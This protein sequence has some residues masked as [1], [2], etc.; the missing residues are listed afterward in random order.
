MRLRCTERLCPFRTAAQRASLSATGGQLDE[1]IDADDKDEVPDSDLFAEMMQEDDE[2]ES[3]HGVEEVLADSMAD[4]GE[5]KKDYIVDLW[6]FARPT[7][8]YVPL[9]RDF[10]MAS[11]GAIC[12]ILTSTAHPASSL[13]AREL[14]CEAY[15]MSERLK[16]HSLLHAQD[17]GMR[18]FLQK[19][20]RELSAADLL[21]GAKR[22]FRPESTFAPFGLCV[23]CSFFLIVCWRFWGVSFV[24][25]ASCFFGGWVISAARPLRTCFAT[26]RRF[27]STRLS[28]MSPAS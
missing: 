8:H 25:V 19:H 21:E 7:A 15:V 9:L 5:K 24:L 22:K 20:L 11:P 1:E 6:C 28:L 26:P 10:G 12:V 3:Q 13:A 17:I 4:V 27:H 16:R 18:I 2:D 23:C 14:G